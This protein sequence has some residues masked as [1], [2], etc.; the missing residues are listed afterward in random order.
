M[1]ILYLLQWC[2]KRSPKIQDI[3]LAKNPVSALFVS[4]QE[5]EDPKP[6]VHITINAV[7]TEHRYNG[8]KTQRITDIS[9][10]V[11]LFLEV[12]LMKCYHNMG[13]TYTTRQYFTFL[14]VP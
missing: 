8:K 10:K 6:C 7:S 12:F 3:G 14:V 13:D 4:K 9:P 2:L 11:S 1:V 5:Y